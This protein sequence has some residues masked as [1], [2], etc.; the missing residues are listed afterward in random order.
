MKE[1]IEFLGI[2]L[3][4]AFTHAGAAVCFSLTVVCVLMI[5]RLHRT[6][7]C[8]DCPFRDG[9]LT[10]RGYFALNASLFVMAM[11]MLLKGVER[12]FDIGVVTVMD[13]LKDA[14]LL[15]M[16]IFWL[17][18]VRKRGVRCANHKD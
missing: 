1:I 14:I 13:I 8:R 10:V 11:V 12:T 18:M 4:H 3:P 9:L 2:R 7:A 17:I 5:H 16:G 15:I 6:E